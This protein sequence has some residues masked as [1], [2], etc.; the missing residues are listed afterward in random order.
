[1]DAASAGLAPVERQSGRHADGCVC[2]RCQGFQPGNGAA[3]KHLAYA[4]LALSDRAQTFAAHLWEAGAG[5]LTDA[6]GPAVAVAALSAV[7]LACATGAVEEVAAA[8]ERGDDM[9]VWLSR[10][11]SRSRLSN[12]ARRWSQTVRQWFDSLGLTE[13]GRAQL[14]AARQPQGIPA[15]EVHELFSVFFRTALEY[16]DGRRR[17]DF[18]RAIES[19][20][21]PD[22]LPVIEAEVIEDAP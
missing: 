18:L 20:S 19:V 3:A 7:Q 15:G 21:P 12:D 8:I 13:V 22:A 4:E 1:V 2:V 10:L 6:D 16:V 17:E 9:D 14:E 5:H 11:E